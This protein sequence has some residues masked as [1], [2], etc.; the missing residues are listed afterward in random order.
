MSLKILYIGEVVGKPG[1]YC[2]KKLLPG[3]K[4]DFDIDF[5]IANCEGATGGFGL[6]KN[7]SIYLKKM[8]IDVETVG[9]KGFYKKDLVEYI[10]KAPYILRP[11]N[12][13]YGVPGRGWRVYSCG[14]AKI[15]I[16]SLLGNS[17]FS[18]THLTNPFLYLPD[19]AEKLKKETSIVILDFHAATTAEKQTMLHLADGRVSAVIGSHTKVLTADEKITAAG[20]AYITDS[21][22]TGSLNSVGGLSPDVEIRKFMTQ[23]PERSKDCWDN[24]ELQ[25]VIIEINEETGKAVKIERIKRSCEIEDGECTKEEL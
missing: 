25:G 12:Y 11:A 9:E 19:S 22:R 15:G 23:I 21:G 3:I 14:E 10:Q 7:H 20:T 6:G 24:L 8:G 4:K 1:V 18:R 16:I 13:P 5:T 17:G 2:V